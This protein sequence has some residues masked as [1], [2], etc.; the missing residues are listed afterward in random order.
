MAGIMAAEASRRS[1]TPAAELQLLAALLLELGLCTIAPMRAVDRDLWVAEQPLRF[2]MLELGTRMTVM[3]LKDS[4]LV[5]YS[6]ITL[7]ETLRGELDALGSVRYLVAPNRFHHLFVSEYSDAYPDAELYVAPGLPEK[8][9]DLAVDG[10]L[11]E[12]APEA[13]RGE[14]ECV[15]FGGLPLANEVVFFHV[16]TRTLLLCDLAFKIGPEAAWLT[17]AAFRLWGRYD[18]LGP[19]RFERLMIRD[20]RAARDS[21][22]RIL[23]LDFERVI[24]AHGTIL[25]SGGPA[26][27]RRGFEW[28]PA[29]PPAPA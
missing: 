6:P 22:E 25:E 28:L 4:S 5:L 16:A 27:L 23:E 19:T 20:K 8:R 15:F 26:A 18:E 10:V 14:L 12:A 13:W 21:L 17:R 9:A 11:P 29:R 7:N 1:W 3:R 2:G 24:V